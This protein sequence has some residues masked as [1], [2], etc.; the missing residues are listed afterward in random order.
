MWI[1]ALI[2]AVLAVLNAV[3]SIWRWR[4]DRSY[5]G[6]AAEVIYGDTRHGL[7]RITNAGTTLAFDAKVAARWNDTDATSPTE[8]ARP[9]YARSDISAFA[10]YPLNAEPAHRCD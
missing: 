8:G 9:G 7:V 10:G 6:W 3:F 4:V 5:V 2:G 1:V